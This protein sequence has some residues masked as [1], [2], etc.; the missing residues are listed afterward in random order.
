MEN[1][2]I[3][4]RIRLVNW[5]LASV[6]LIS[7]SLW[8]AFPQFMSVRGGGYIIIAIL[9]TLLLYK[10]LLL[11]R[12]GWD[13]NYHQVKGKLPWLIYLAFMALTIHYFLESTYWG[14][15]R[16]KAIHAIEEKFKTDIK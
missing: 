13:E 9:G 16:Q 4:T 15:K 12:N 8:I 5:A 1:H 11:K 3:V 7:L 14:P 10:I 2:Q 6:V